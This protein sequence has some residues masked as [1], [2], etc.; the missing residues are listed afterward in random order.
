MKQNWKQQLAIELFSQKIIKFKR[1]KL[2]TLYRDETWSADLSAKP[3]LGNN[4]N[5]YK[6]LITVMDILS[7]KARGYTFK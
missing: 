6:K 7:K 4:D 3:F 5:N 2:K 1:E